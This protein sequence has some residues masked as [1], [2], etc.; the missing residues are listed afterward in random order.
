MVPEISSVTD[1]IFGHFGPFLILLPPNNPKNENFEKMKKKK[2]P[3]D[4]ITLHMFHKWKLY[5]VWFL[6]YEVWL[7]QFFFILDRFLP[8]Y[9]T[10]NSKNQNFEKMKKMSRDIIILHKCTKNRDHMLYCSWEMVR[11]RCNCYFLFW[12]ILWPFSP[13]TAP[14]IL[15][16]DNVWFLR[17]V[18]QWMNERMDGKSDIKRWLPH[19]KIK[20]KVNRQAITANCCVTLKWLITSWNKLILKH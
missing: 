4:I 14:K 16:S 13:L 1:T 17:C 6:R 20:I 9:P 11:D 10:N 12:T 8:F 3:K 18:V 2:T 5:D 19:L 15:W 7:T